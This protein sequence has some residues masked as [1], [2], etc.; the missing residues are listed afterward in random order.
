MA[1][2][3][4][5]AF[6]EHYMREACAA[7]AEEKIT[8]ALV[9]TFPARCG[10][11]PLTGEELAALTDA[12]GDIEQVELFGCACLKGFPEIGKS[13]RKMNIHQMEQCF[14]LAADPTLVRVCLK[15][16][17][18]L[19]T[20]GWLIQWPVHME[21][22]GFDR[23]QVRQLFAETTSVIVLLETGVDGS[24]AAKLHEFADYV[25]RPFEVLYTGLAS[26]RL[27]LARAYLLWRTE[28]QKITFTEQIQ[29]LRKKAAMHAMSIDLISKLARIGNESEAV[30]TM[31][32]VYEILFAPQR[33]SYLSFEEGAPGKLWT[34][35]E[36]TAQNPEKEEIKKT[37]AAF[38]EESGYALSNGGFVLRIV[39]RGEIRGVIAVENIA[40]SQY[41]HQYLNLALSI[42]DI[43]ELPVE[44]ARKY[45]KLVRTEEM[46][47]K[48]NEEL[49]FLS[50]TDAL[51]GIA[52]RRAYDECVEVEWRKMLR[53]NTPLS[54]IICDIDFFKK[55][56]DCYGH[57]GG[58]TCLHTVAQIIRKLVLRPGD[59][60]ARYGGEEFAI[61]LPNTPAEGALH[62]AEKIRMEVIQY[63]IPHEDS[64]IAACVTLSLGVAGV[65][66]PQPEDMTPALMFRVADTALY[67][68]KNK[69]RNRTV[70]K[71]IEAQIT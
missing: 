9:V 63:N 70:M 36:L 67:L 60:V 49:Y 61:V 39:R 15:K 42:V 2:R 32:D 62:I 35:P 47:R 7:L 48:A 18:Y 50:T 45:E 68:A 53:N 5:F 12:Q 34:R 6:C 55:Y 43:C 21:K 65:D 69:G 66:P 71:K 58:D 56:N 64:D 29:E 26:M 3:L 59:F 27:H 25:N 23:D 37:L 51:T 38:S 10:R 22:M 17:A 13:G 33:L 4:A 46:L 54:L 30:E 11:P 52:N 19:T 20:P 44:N 1:G 57:K 41:I 24:S 40:F 16:G 8:D 28:K 14:D 31:L